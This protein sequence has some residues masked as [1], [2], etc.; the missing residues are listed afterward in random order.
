MLNIR[1]FDFVSLKNTFHMKNLLLF[2][3]MLISFSVF[4]QGQIEW[5]KLPDFENKAGAEILFQNK[6]GTLIAFSPNQGPYKISV[7]I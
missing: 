6:Y 5:E 1:I 4:S 2:F 7:L 3:T